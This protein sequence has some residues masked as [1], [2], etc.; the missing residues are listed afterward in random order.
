M[1]QTQE[2]TAVLSQYVTTIDRVIQ[3]ELS[4]G[5][6]EWMQ[7]ALE[8]HFG[9]RDADFRPLADGKTGKRLRPVM[10]LLAYRGALESVHPGAAVNASLEPVLPLAAAVE[11]VHNYSLIHDDIEDEDR[12]R[13]GRTT[14]WAMWGKP[15]AINAGDCLDM[16]AFRS[17]LR[18]AERGVDAAR[19]VKLVDALTRTSIRLTLGQQS[20]MSFEDDLAVTPEMYLK[21]I[22]GKS[23]A[24]ISCATYSGAL[25]ALG[26]GQPG[27]DRRLADYALF[28]EEIGLGFQIRDDILGIWGLSADTGKPSGSDIRRRKKSLPVIYALT[29]A[30]AA[31]RQKLLELYRSTAPVSP[32]QEQY[33]ISA[34]EECGA[35]TYA[36]SQA[37]LY[38]ETA[39]AALADA[40]GGGAALERNEPL[41]QLRDLCTFLVERNY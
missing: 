6:D 18:S 8:Y 25:V 12:T 24:L 39:L 38:K 36:Q 41:H 28:G 27:N 20:D 35:R 3:A 19:L 29:N 34:L 17:L 10:A 15:K 2:I 40:A 4:D 1:I 26:P 37:D 21:M 11:M 31:V 5:L 13:H 22:G 32:S 16:L 33:I 23:A 9:W 7:G 30:P 14:L